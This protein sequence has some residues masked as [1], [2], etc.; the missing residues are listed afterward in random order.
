MKNLKLGGQKFERSWEGEKNM[1]KLFEK[2]ISNEE[3]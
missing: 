1:K 3:R 2:N